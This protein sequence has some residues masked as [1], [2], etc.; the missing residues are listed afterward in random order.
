MPEPSKLTPLLQN[1]EASTVR[2]TPGTQVPDSD[3]FGATI[4]PDPK[5]PSQGGV[6]PTI[7]SR[8]LPL[9]NRERYLLDGVVAEGGHGR[10]LRAQDLHLER[11]VALKEP[12]SAGSSTE[13][14]FL[15]EARITAR[16]Q[17]P[18]I[19][20]VYEAGRWPG[21]EP[22]YAMK[23]LSGRSLA[24]LIDSLS[25]LSERLSALP[26]VLAV[27]EAMAYAHSQRV[28]HRD[29]KPSNILV[30][31]FGETVVIDWG[32]A[33]ELDKPELPFSA[34]STTPTGSPEPERTQMGTIL[35]TPAYMPPEQALGQPVD[36]RADVYALGSILYHL[37]SGQ[38]P[39]LGTTSQEVLQRVITEEPAPLA[40]L[41]PRLTQDLLDIVSRAMARD[42]AHRYPSARELAEDLRRFT[43]GQLVG[44]HRY[45]R[46]ERMLRFARRHRTSL[47]VAAFA[48]LAIMAAVVIDH[49]RIVQERDRAEQKQAAAEKAEREASQR[50]DSLTIVEARTQV[51]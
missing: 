24:R 29:L 51:S 25:S 35:G 17:H 32:L 40:Q 12:I 42:P 11:P 1:M 45:T 15:R 2:R 16:L 49:Y 19:V 33:K 46:R 44:A 30:G 43:Q 47:I 9:V 18:S 50:A 41:Q 20:P 23:L 13:E 48:I 7:R 4:H 39:Y 21:G 3:P 27:A 36:E 5:T 10:I 22:F 28:I 14:R 38:A 8:N 34:T 6:D 31:E 26:H 37:L